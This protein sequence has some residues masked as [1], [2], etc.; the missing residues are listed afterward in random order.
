MQSKPTDERSDLYSLG[1]S[2][3]QMVTGKR[4]FSVTSSFSIMQAQ[5]QEI[6]RPPIEIV[7]TLPPALNT[8]IMMAVAKDPAQRFQS[9]DAFRN[10]LSQGAVS[11][12]AQPAL[13]QGP[14]T[15]AFIDGTAG[16]APTEARPAMDPGFTVP[17]PIE[18]ESQRSRNFLL[19]VGVVAVAALLAGGAVYKTRQRH[20]LDQAAV[21]TAATSTSQATATA[22][23]DN[24]AAQSQTMPPEQAPPDE[25][26]PTAPPPAAQKSGAR[27]ENP[28]TPS[29]PSAE[30]IQAQQQA[31]LEQKRLL[32][33]METE[34]DQ[35]D[36]RAASVESSLDALEQQMH[37]SGLGLRG[38][39][40]TAR[41]NMRTD[42]AKAHQAMEAN[43]TERARRY[44]DMAHREVEKLE[45][46]MG[47]R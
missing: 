24:T 41:G 11:P 46:F 15:A 27:R 32:D 45:A 47:R 29:G 18:P 33:A 23:A 21:A 7:P 37:Q 9:A 16:P 31:A 26:K 3:Y 10:A 28:D 13:G 40:V 44:L 30:E 2:L 20:E 38:D 34:I 36:G 14:A 25:A 39:M 35:L 8:I 1:V 19:V 6:P 43:D 12:A 5:V 22:P 4:M 42:L 17:T